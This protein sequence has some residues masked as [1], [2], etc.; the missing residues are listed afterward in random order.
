LFKFD[1]CSKIEIIKKIDIHLKFEIL[2]DLEICSKFEIHSD[3]EICSKFEIRSD[4]EIYS[5]FEICSDLIM[6][7]L[8]RRIENSEKKELGRPIHHVWVCGSWSTPTGVVYMRP[9]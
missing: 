3:L 6:L 9:S 5:K 4:F 1:F 2:L 7:R 8:K